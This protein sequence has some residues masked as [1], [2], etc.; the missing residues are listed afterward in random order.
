LFDP[1]SMDN[2]FKILSIL[3]VTK[4]KGFGFYCS[5]YSR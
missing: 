2:Y 5:L 3:L 1:I 4:G